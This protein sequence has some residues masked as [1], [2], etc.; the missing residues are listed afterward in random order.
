[1]IPCMCVAASSFF[2]LCCQP[3]EGR[4]GVTRGSEKG[5]CLKADI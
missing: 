4:V 5:V 1:M 3:G 2:G